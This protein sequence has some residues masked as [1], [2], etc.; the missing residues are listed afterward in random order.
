MININRKKGLISNSTQCFS[1]NSTQWYIANRR[2]F[3]TPN[4]TQCFSLASLHH[5]LNPIVALSARNHWK[6]PGRSAKLSQP[7][8]RP[9]NRIACR[10]LS[11]LFVWAGNFSSE[12]SSCSYRHLCHTRGRI[13][14]FYGI[15]FSSACS[16]GR[17]LCKSGT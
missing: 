13:E 5:L 17:I 4:S 3:L 11:C 8:R 15:F 9:L 12:T 7:G 16:A 14:F 10:A 2:K 1:P 6:L